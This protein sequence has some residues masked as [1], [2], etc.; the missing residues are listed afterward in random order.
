MAPSHQARGPGEGP[1]GRLGHDAVRG[2]R[3]L[4]GRIPWGPSL[5][6]FR[7]VPMLRLAPFKAREHSSD[8]GDVGE[9][10]EAAHREGTAL[11]PLLALDRAEAPG[12]K[13]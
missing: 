11:E 12:G 8:A 9:P 4:T 6:R 10:T 3:S 2:H 1:P 5:G 7:T 13:T